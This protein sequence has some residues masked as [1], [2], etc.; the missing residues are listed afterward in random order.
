MTATFLTKVIPCSECG[1]EFNAQIVKLFGVPDRPLSTLCYDCRA[2]KRAELERQ[3][4]AQQELKVKALKLQWLRNSGIPSKFLNESLDTFEDRSGNTANRLNI[5]REYA[6]N[7][8]SL[9]ATGY[10]SLILL[11]AGAWGVGKS[12]LACGIARAIIEKWLPLSTQSPVY[13]I[14]EPT[15]LRRIRATYNRDNSESEEQVFEHLINVPLLIVDDV[16]KEEVSDPRF[17]Q[18]VWFSV[19]NGR[20]ENELP[21]VI[22]ANLTAEGMMTHLGGSRGNEATF[23]RLFEMIQGVMYEVKAAGSKRREA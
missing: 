9:R 2:I 23:D 19:I 17:V 12:H 8:G 1:K 15:M 13:Y 16:G 20:Y 22:T 14:T 18:R 7:F 10:K 5:C 21:V 4:K 3:E 11:S 6:D